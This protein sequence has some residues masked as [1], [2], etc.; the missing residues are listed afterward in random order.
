M[1]EVMKFF[2][3]QRLD[4]PLFFWRDQTGHEIDLIVAYSDALYPVEIKS[5][6]TPA[7]DMF[8]GLKWWTQLA[9]RSAGSPTRVYGGAE[10]Y[11]R[12]GIALRPWFSV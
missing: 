11:V 7:E 2:Y 9:G 10:A 3:N 4:P 1:A 5:G 12:D 6:S 8:K